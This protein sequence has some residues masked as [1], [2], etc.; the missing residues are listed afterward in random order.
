VNPPPSL[1][2]F[3]FAPPA[4]YHWLIDRGLVG[5]TVFSPLQPWYFL[6]R[7]DAFIL[8][9]GLFA[10]ARRQDNDDIAC[11]A[12]RDGTPWIVIVH[13]WTP[14][15][16]QIVATHDTIWDWL[17]TVIDEIAEWVEMGDQE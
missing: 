6:S 17:K 9:G 16:H 2:A 12:S 7:D 13:G 1:P 15:G 10:F 5:F 11:F 14:T 3:P 4:G 8:D